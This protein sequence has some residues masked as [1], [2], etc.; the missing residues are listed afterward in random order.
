VSIHGS[1]GGCQADDADHNENYGPGLSK[2][3]AAAGLLEEKQH[4]HG[5]DY[6][7]SH[8]TAD[9]TAATIATNAV[10]HM[11]WPPTTFVAPISVAFFCGAT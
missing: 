6:R 9:G 10:T 1:H 11:Y 3:K 2:G 7:R 8:Q 5:D 4:T